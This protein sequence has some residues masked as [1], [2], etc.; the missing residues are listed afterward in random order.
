VLRSNRW[1]GAFALAC[2]DKFA[3]LYVGDGQKDFGNPTQSFFPPALPTLQKEYAVDVSTSEQ[4][5]V[6]QTD[7]SVEEEKKFQDSKKLPE[8]DRQKNDDDEEGE[9]QEDDK[10]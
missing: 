7:P 3:N 4:L 5:L 1:P 8:Q 9:E 6:E 2:N 10:E